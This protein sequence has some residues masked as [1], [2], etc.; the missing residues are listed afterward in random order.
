MERL[1]IIDSIRRA[2]QTENVQDLGAYEHVRDFKSIIN[3]YIR[4]I[5]H[6]SVKI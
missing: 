2:L 1:G 3:N 5:C 4:R 6:N